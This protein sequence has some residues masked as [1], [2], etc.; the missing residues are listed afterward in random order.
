MTSPKTLQILK[1][2]FGDTISL[3][4]FGRVQDAA[5]EIDDIVLRIESDQDPD[6]GFLLP[7][8]CRSL[9][10]TKISARK[11]DEKISKLFHMNYT[12]RQISEALAKENIY[13]SPSTVKEHRTHMGLLRGQGP[14]WS[15]KDVDPALVIE[16]K[17]SG[18]SWP[19]VKAEVLKRTGI[20]ISAS[21]LQDRYYGAK[22]EA[23]VV[24]ESAA[25][26]VP[27]AGLRSAAQN[28]DSNIICHPAPDLSDAMV[29]NVAEADQSG[30][31]R[32]THEPSSNPDTLPEP[33][34][35]YE[36]SQPATICYKGP[37]ISMSPEEAGQI[38]KGSPLAEDIRTKALDLVDSGKTCKEAA[39]MIGVEMTLARSWVGNRKAQE[40]FARKRAARAEEPLIAPEVKPDPI[41]YAA[42]KPAPA[43][44]KPALQDDEID[45]LIWDFMEKGCK[46][47]MQA[48]LGLKARGVGMSVGD[49]ADRYDAMK[50][51]KGAEEE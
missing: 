21:A 25:E 12:D 34:H 51:E 36:H 41:Q 2:L 15:K 42:P 35:P 33:E 30:P 20:E 16:L 9:P 22:D 8:G 6:T 23:E 11:F 44:E 27:S 32:P 18:L 29:R 31:V 50:A 1:I 19:G 13:R 17:D 10:G 14:G 24:Q 26:E 39:Q 7:K 28:N 46:S 43:E 37:S 3:Q 40:A 5:E 38:A 49:I 4:E 47:F 48:R 45:D